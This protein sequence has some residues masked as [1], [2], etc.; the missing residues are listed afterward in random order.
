[1]MLAAISRG[2][3]R[4]AQDAYLVLAADPLLFREESA[5]LRAACRRLLAMRVHGTEFQTAV[6]DFA[7]KIAHTMNAEPLVAST[8]VRLGTRSHILVNE[9]RI[10]QNR[11]G[12]GSVTEST[13]LKGP[14]RVP[15]WP[16]SR[17]FRSGDNQ[18]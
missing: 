18:Y 9:A 12:S 11:L 5:L 17:G 13:P 8:Q 4:C 16:A 14:A 3:L 10:N 6:F 7:T 2:N 1:M 15:Q